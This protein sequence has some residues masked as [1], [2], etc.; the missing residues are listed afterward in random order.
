[1]ISAVML[2]Y[3]IYVREFRESVYDGRAIKNQTDIG[4][5]T[6]LA[7]S[8]TP[9]NSEQNIIIPPASNATE[10][11]KREF[12]DK[13]SGIAQ[14]APYLQIEAD[15]IVNPLVI[16]LRSDIFRVKNTDINDHTLTFDPANSFFIRTG[17]TK[18]FKIIFN[19]GPGIYG[20]GC[21]HSM[22]AVGMVYFLP[23]E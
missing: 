4:R 2:G 7:L 6:G 18:H 9:L 22:N 11:E 13:I 23:S 20:Y 10:A 14:E 17:E 15:C 16:Q 1:M 12:F 3:L 5:R 21:G 8:D 19:K